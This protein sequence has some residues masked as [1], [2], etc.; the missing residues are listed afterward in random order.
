MYLELM[1]PRLYRQTKN[2]LRKRLEK[3]GYDLTYYD[4]D[5]RTALKN[6]NNFAMHG[7]GSIPPNP[8]K[9]FGGPEFSPKEFIDWCLEA[10]A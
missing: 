7:E 8:K 2:R 3:K 6:W 4:T 5:F 9:V 1:D 10:W